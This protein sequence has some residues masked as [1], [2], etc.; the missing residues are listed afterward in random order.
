MT[1]T[2]AQGQVCETHKEPLRWH[3]RYNHWFCPRCHG[4]RISAGWDARR[5]RRRAADADLFC[6]MAG[7]VRAFAA[8]TGE[9]A[10]PAWVLDECD[11]LNDLLGKEEGGP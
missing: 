10:L 11:A 2:P 3:R 6:R 1:Q 7:V 9:G 8:F 4:E 5:E